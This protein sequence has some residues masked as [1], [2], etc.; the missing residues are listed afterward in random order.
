MVIQSCYFFYNCQTGMLFFKC[1]SKLTKLFYFILV[2]NL[3]QPVNNNANISVQITISKLQNID[4]IYF[5]DSCGYS[6]FLFILSA[7][8]SMTRDVLQ[9]H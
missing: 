3:L 1:L 8:M 6:D 7:K 5:C 4:A 9:I 2:K